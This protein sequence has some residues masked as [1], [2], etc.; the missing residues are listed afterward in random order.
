MVMVPDSPIA[1]NALFRRFVIHLEDIM[2]KFTPYMS[3]KV[4]KGQNG[5]L[6]GTLEEKTRLYNFIANSLVVE[7]AVSM[8]L[9]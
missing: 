5:T 1:S 4:P 9:Q 6:N 7:S 2:V 8:P 3:V